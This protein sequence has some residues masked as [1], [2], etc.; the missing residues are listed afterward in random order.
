M[1]V[2]NA[3]ADEDERMNEIESLIKRLDKDDDSKILMMITSQRLSDL[4][5]STDQCEFI[6][7]FCT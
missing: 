7:N 1:Q 3:D 5:N 6:S 2:R 4:K